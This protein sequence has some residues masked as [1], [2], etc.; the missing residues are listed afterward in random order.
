MTVTATPVPALPYTRP[1][2]Q[3]WAWDVRVVIYLGLGY[4]FLQLCQGAW[5]L[6]SIVRDRQITWFTGNFYGWYYVISALLRALLPT[7][8]VVALLGLLRFRKG[9]RR[10]GVLTAGAFL[11]FGVAEFATNLVS[12]LFH[13]RWD[14]EF[15]NYLLAVLQNVIHGYALLIILVVT[16]CRA[17]V[18]FI[19]DNAGTVEPN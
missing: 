2:A 1:L 13:N 19:A 9:A 16:L 4:A 11:L 6:A 10:L 17:D 18:R 5:G 15:P 7:L 14:S 12:L 8:M 3:K